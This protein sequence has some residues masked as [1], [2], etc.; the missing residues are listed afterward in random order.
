MQTR[1]AIIAVAAI[2]QLATNAA[3]AQDIAAGERIAQTWCGNRHIVDR[4]NKPAG[5]DAVPTFAS[6][7]AMKSTTE[8]SL[9]AFLTTPHGR[10]PD[11][12]LSH[13]EIQDVVA[14]I[15]SLRSR[16]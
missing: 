8:M 4:K 3:G 9:D 11:L 6:I 15:L 1:S 14:Y 7:A 10:M 12:V 5:S 13:T 16:P 2:A